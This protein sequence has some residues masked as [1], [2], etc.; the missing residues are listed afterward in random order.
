MLKIHHKDP[1]LNNS[2]K[3]VKST[4]QIINIQTPVSNVEYANG[5]T[6]SISFTSI[7]FS[8]GCAFL[9]CAFLSLSA[10]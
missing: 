5:F 9:A 10:A 6:D 4:F 2:L 1:K 8:I 3:Y 7:K